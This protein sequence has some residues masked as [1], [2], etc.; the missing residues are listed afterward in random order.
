MSGDI[1]YFFP[2]PYDF[3]MD[4]TMREMIAEAKDLYNVYAAGKNR[5]EREMTDALAIFLRS[6][7][8]IGRGFHAGSQCEGERELMRM[9]ADE[10]R[11]IF[12]ED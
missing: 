6:L 4:R 12:G 8:D 3:L 7:L 11:I 1:V 2:L 9:F 10:L 5:G